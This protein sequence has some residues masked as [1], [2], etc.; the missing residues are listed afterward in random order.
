MILLCTA[1]SMN[2]CQ[3]LFYI[4]LMIN[5]L[6]EYLCLVGLYVQNGD[7]KKYFRIDGFAMTMYVIMLAF[8][9]IALIVSFYAYR[10]FKGYAYD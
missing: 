1:Y 6:V 10:E 7:F 3:L 5:D 2:F 9:I 8:S 4:M